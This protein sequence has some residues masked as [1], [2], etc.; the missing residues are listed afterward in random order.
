MLHLVGIGLT[1]ADLPAGSLEICKRCALYA[2][3]YTTYVPQDRIDQIEYLTGRSVK[4]LD[5]SM[6]E[7]SLP[8]LLGEAENKDVAILIGGDPLIATTHKIIFI[9]AKKAGIE[10]RVHHAA[11]IITVLIGESGLDFYRFGQM[12]TIAKWTDN[13]KPVS[14]YETIQRNLASNLHSTVFLDYEISNNSSLELSKAIRILRE[15]ESS[16][17]GKII[18]DA[19]SVIV[20]HSMSHHNERKMFTTIAEASGM[21]LDPGPTSI[22]IPAKLSDIEKEAISSMY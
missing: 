11:S 19:T 3:N 21:V 14:F 10:V 15:A 12:C 7:E 8:V 17:N 18:D 13:Y 5:R 4:R 22:I 2:D 16:Y 1:K 20:M 9:A 6:L